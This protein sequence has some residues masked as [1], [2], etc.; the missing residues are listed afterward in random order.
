MVYVNVD[1]K[2]P[3]CMFIM[4]VRVVEYDKDTKKFSA[5]TIRSCVFVIE[6]L[7]VFLI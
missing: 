7:F 4:S 3:C 6:L 5:C 2:F 1:G